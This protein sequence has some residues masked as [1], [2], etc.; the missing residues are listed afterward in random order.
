MEI[1]FGNGQA[2]GLIEGLKGRTSL[3]WERNG[4]GQAEVPGGGVISRSCVRRQHQN[5]LHF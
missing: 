5:G 1:I 4:V 3:G 2:R